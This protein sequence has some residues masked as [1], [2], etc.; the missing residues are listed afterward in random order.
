M[1]VTVEKQD[2]A[3]LVK[4]SGEVDMNN[5]PQLRKALMGL[6]EARS[7]MIIVSL[8]GV[9]YIATAGIATLVECRQKVAQYKGKLRLAEIRKDMFEIFKMAKLDGIFD[10]YTTEQEALA[11]VREKA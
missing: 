3:C 1:N 2:A 5:A 7:P 10:I 8:A 6:V 11:G 9:R 4:V